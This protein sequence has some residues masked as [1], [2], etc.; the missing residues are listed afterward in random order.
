MHT[1]SIIIEV[2]KSF[3]YFP[4]LDSKNGDENWIQK[5]DSVLIIVLDSKMD[6][7]MDSVIN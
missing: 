7:K 6:S 4:V 5:L 2:T 3:Y 1:S